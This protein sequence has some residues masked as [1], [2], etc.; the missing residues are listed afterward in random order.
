MLVMMASLAAR[1][2][3]AVAGVVT[4]DEVC[5]ATADYFLG[6][7]DYPEALKAHL[8]VIAAHPEDALAHYHLGFACGML[9]RQGEEHAEYRRAASLGIKQWN[10]FLNLGL[11]YLEEGNVDAA[12]EALTTAVSLGPDRS[13][14]HI[15]FAYN[16]H[17]RE[18]VTHM[19]RISLNPTPGENR[20]H[21]LCDAIFHAH[22]NVNSDHK[23]R[24]AIA[25]CGRAEYAK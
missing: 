7:E 8:R 6:I 16:R 22:L 24:R 21:S 9:G 4:K 3:T 18:R 2:V 1:G 13:E 17:G 5:D 19:N 12:T 20:V 10:R 25:W 14:T 11:A 23:S 15:D